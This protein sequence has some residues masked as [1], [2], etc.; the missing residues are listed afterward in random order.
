[1][2]IYRGEG[3]TVVTNTAGEWVTLLTSGKGMDLAI[4]ML[5]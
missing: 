5:P 1:M 4:R 2:N 3:L